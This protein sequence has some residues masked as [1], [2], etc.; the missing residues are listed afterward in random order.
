MES[1]PELFKTDMRL[2]QSI[3]VD[4]FKARRSSVPI[5]ELWD[6]VRPTIPDSVLKYAE[7]VGGKTICRAALKREGENGLPLA[8]P[9][10]D[11]ENSWQQLPLFTY[12]ELSALI[13]RESRSIESDIRK[14]R[15]LRD[16]CVDRFGMA[17][18]I[19]SLGAVGQSAVA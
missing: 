17:P 8:K 10:D 19:P 9:L 18:E 3:I 2:A 11:D 6:E 5:T 4:A 15:R 1:Q 13:I 7:S 16:Y 12:E 14:L